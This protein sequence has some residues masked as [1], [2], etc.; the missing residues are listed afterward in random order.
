MGYSWTDNNINAHHFLTAIISIVHNGIVENYDFL[1][2][3][4]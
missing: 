4:V 1:K 2:E 3:K